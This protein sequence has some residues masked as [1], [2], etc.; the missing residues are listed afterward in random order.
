MSWHEVQSIEMDSS[1][2]AHAITWCLLTFAYSQACSITLRDQQS[3]FESLRRLCVTSLLVGNTSVFAGTLLPVLSPWY[4]IQ[5]W[6]TRYWLPSVWLT[7]HSTAQWFRNSIE[8]HKIEA[9][10]LKVWLA[11]L[12]GWST[13]SQ[14]AICKRICQEKTAETIWSP[15]NMQDTAA[16]ATNHS[17]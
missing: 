13:F 12:L 9:R 14:C 7:C 8:D 4:P 16:E 11:H 17:K 3:M 5:I 15:W 1:A 6:E 10:K 2:V